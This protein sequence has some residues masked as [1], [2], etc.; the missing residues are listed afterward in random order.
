M[1]VRARGANA[2]A[3]AQFEN[4]Y[5]TPP[6]GNWVKLAFVSSDLG[7]E[8]GLIESD[9][10]GQ[11]REPY[12]PTEDVA[13][14]AGDL[15]VPVDARLF[16]Y[17]LKLML[18]APVSGPGD[19]A[20]GSYAF[21]D[22]PAVDST[23][24]VNGTAFT[25]KAAGAAGNQINIGADL[26]ATLT[27]IATKL[28]ASVVIGVALATY[29]AGATKLTVTHDAAGVAGNGFTLAAGAGSNATPSGAT[30]TG[31]N[32]QHVFTTG[33][34]TLPSISL[35]IGLLGLAKPYSVNYGLRGNTLKIQQQRSGLLNAT[36]NLIG[37]GETLP[38]ATSAAGTPTELDVARFAQATGYVK[39]DGVVLGEVVSNGFSLSNNLD[40]DEVIRPDGRINDVDPGMVMINLTP[41]VKYTDDG[42]KVLAENKTPVE[43]EI[44]WTNAVGSLTI[45]VPRVFLPK[46][47]NSISGPKGIQATYNCQASGT[48]GASATITLKNDVAGY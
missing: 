29:S 23:I 27:A 5:G 10:L 12:D 30:L 4:A 44:G 41:V 2:A 43:F 7:E 34:G 21:S 31:G 16:G 46:V 42:F 39:R 25:F 9:L 1:V 20:T 8:R 3:H 14:N 18:G 36:L 33:G 37:Q 22:Q 48:D 26:A 38:A 13:T 24:T 6:G 45:V 19:A 17:H 47:K 32:Y 15:V 40:P 35:E 28:N 11:G